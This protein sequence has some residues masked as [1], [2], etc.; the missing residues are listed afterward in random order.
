MP[1]PQTLLATAVTLAA[2]ALA[3]PAAADPPA[4]AGNPNC[5]AQFVLVGV[6]QPPWGA[7][8]RTFAQDFHPLG[9]TISAQAQSPKEDCLFKP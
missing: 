4:A 8:V 7:T 9:Q 5:V 1:R 2:L 3:A 6:Q